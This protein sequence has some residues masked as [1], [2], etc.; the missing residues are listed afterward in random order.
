MDPRPSPEAAPNVTLS[1]PLV[2][3]GM[4]AYI[5]RQRFKLAPMALPV[6]PWI[7][8]EDLENTGIFIEAGFNKELEARTTRP[9]V[10]VDQ[11]QNVYTRSSLGHQDQNPIDFKT[12]REEFHIFGNIDV[13]ID[14]TSPNNGESLMLGSIVQDFIQMS[15]FLIQKWF[16][17]REISEVLLNRTA[18]FEQ[19]DQLWNTQVQFRLGYETR[20]AAMQILPLLNQIE[21]T[22]KDI[23]V[24][25][26]EAR[27]ILIQRMFEE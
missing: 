3:I 8:N 10:W 17:M 27:R 2:V 15:T 19:D 14:C 1:T 25:P 13:A 6:L 16:G 24:N 9:G 7:W 21:M 4:V 22:L 20:W 26:E 12:S 11:M 18:P 23:S 5:I